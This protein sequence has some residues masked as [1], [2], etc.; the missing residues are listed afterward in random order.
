MLKFFLNTSYQ[1][2]LLIRLEQYLVRKRIKILPQFV[3][4]WIFILYN[5]DVSPMA[6]IGKNLKIAHPSGIVIGANSVIGD[7]VTI[8][9]QVTFGS[10]GRGEGYQKQYPT[11]EDNVVIYAGAKIIGGVTIGR[12]S[13]IGANAVVNRD[14]PPYS[15]AVGVP[16]KV[17]KELNDGQ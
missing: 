15:L 3:Y 17:I 7:N 2:Q 6:V 4:Y 9:Q 5:C 10:H 12:G 8:F 11:I 14:I 13:V 16:A 1:I